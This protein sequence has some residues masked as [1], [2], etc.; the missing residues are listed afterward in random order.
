MSCVKIERYRGVHGQQNVA[1]TSEALEACG[2][3]IL[4]APDPTVAPFEYLVRLPSGEQRELVCYAFTANKYR[5]RGRPADEHR[6]QVKY[7]S[8]FT[9]YHNVYIDPT[10]R[11]TTLFFGVHHE[12]NLFVAVDPF[13]HAPTWFSRSIEL[14]EPELLKARKQG[15]HGWERERSM[16]RRK[17]A[18]PLESFQTEAVNAFKAEHFLNY[19]EFERLASGLDASERLLI[20]EQIARNGASTQTQKHALEQELGLSR[21]ELLDVLGGTFRLMVAV[22]GRVAEHHLGRHLLGIRGVSA[23]AAIDEDGQPDFSLRYKK[24]DFRVECKNVR[25]GLVPPRVDFQKTRAAKGDPCSRYYS[26]QQFDVLAACMHPVTGRWEYQF[27]ATRVLAKHKRCPDKLADNV[28]IGGEA[29]SAN[30]IVALDQM[31]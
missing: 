21:D 15:W 26:A 16:A 20:G 13:M 28:V 4:S 17:A 23:V 3:K 31:L 5:Q 29:W 22:R 6:L 1:K 27:C 8:D 12:L 25:R 10:R 30:L 11:R 24:R 19:I 18:P 14:K 7:G 9:R 2:V